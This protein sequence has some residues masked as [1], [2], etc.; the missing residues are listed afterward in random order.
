M[1]KVELGLNLRGARIVTA[2]TQVV[3]FLA[4]L[5]E[6]ALVILFGLCVEHLARVAKSTDTDSGVPSSALFSELSSS[7]A[8]PPLRP[9]RRS[10]E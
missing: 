1:E 3:E 7:A 5:D 4:E 8:A 10:S 6:S 9:L 2:L